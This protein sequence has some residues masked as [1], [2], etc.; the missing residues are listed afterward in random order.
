[1]ILPD[2]LIAI[3]IKTEPPSA[4]YIIEKTARMFAQRNTSV[5][6]PA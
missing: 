4:V 1:M 6:G 3:Y 2:C 5:I